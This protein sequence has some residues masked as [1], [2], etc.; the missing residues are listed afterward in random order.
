[1]RFVPGPDLPSGGKIVGLDGVREAYETGRGKFV[2]RAT[3]RVEKVT[4]RREG[5]VFTELP[6]LVGPEQVIEKI[7]EAVS[8]K[9]LEGVSAVVDL[10]DRHHGLRLVDRGQE[11]F[12]SRRRAGAAV[13][14]HPA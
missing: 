10:T 3:V 12:Q 13:S 4:A 11:R 8:A 6:Y 7:K 5:L 9:K 1:M 2:T 14:P